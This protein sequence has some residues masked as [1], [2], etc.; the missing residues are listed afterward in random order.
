MKEACNENKA[1]IND[2][3][4]QSEKRTDNHK[5]N[6]RPFS[7]TTRQTDSREKD[8]SQGFDIIDSENQSNASDKSQSTVVEKGALEPTTEGSSGS[9]ELSNKPELTGTLSLEDVA[10][11]RAITEGE[12]MEAE[13]T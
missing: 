4:K 13:E 10:G 8:K 3:D 1:V 5:R 9:T 7:N 12:S 2:R 6:R 11:T